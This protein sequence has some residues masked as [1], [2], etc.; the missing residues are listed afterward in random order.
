MNSKCEECEGA[1]LVLV[2]GLR[3]W[4]GSAGWGF[5]EGFEVVGFWGGRGWGGLCARGLGEG[6]VAVFSLYSLGGWLCL[7]VVIPCIY[8][9]LRWKGLLIAAEVGG[10]V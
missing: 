1:R 8:C 6:D 10:R 2:M 9:G 4:K 7:A 5:V 3:G